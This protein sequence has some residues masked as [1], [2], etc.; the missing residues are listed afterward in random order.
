M[1]TKARRKI[2]WGSRYLHGLKVIPHKKLGSCKGKIL[3]IQR[4][5]WMI[6]RVMNINMTNGK[7]DTSRCGTLKRTQPHL[8]SI[9][10]RN[11]H[12]YYNHK[13]ETRQ[14]QNVEHSIKM[15][16]KRQKLATEMFQID[17]DWRYMMTKDNT[18]SQTGSFTRQKICCKGHYWINWQNWST[19]GMLN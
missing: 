16:H 12:F 1:N 2:W 9:P 4:R 5:N 13:E 10:A 14:T 7:M 17:W 19:G 8:C 18:W 11:A 3:T 6:D 15:C